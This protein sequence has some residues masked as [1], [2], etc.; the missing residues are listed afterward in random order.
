[1]N[2]YKL[3]QTTIRC[4]INVIEEKRYIKIKNK[5]H[6]DTF[7]S[8]NENENPLNKPKKTNLKDKRD[9]SLFSS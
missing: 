7:I 3:L 2:A 9:F 5:K 4:F 6:K 1:M 8:K